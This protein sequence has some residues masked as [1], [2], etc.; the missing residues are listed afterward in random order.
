MYISHLKV[1]HSLN[2]RPGATIADSHG[3]RVRDDAEYQARSD[4]ARNH[5]LAWQ[6]S[7]NSRN[8]HVLAMKNLFAL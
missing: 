3:F 6:T 2:E 7:P 5:S 1:T 8:F 4:E